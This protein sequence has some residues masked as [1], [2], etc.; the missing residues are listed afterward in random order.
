MSPSSSRGRSA[1]SLASRALEE[2]AEMRRNRPV[3]S[4]A[5]WVTRIPVLAGKG[6]VQPLHL[7]PLLDELEKI[8]RGEQ[9]R[10]VCHTPPRGGKT[11]TL[12]AAIS[13]WLKAHPT[14]QI[15]YTSYNATQARSKAENARDWAKAMG[16]EVT[17][18]TVVEWRTP[19]G[20]GCIAR[21]ISEGIT[22]QGVDVAIVDDPVKD[23]VEAESSLKRQRALDWFNEALFTRGN[24]NLIG[25]A[26]K[27]PRSII[28]NMARWHP[29]D[30]AGSLVAQG[31]KYIKLKAIDEVEINGALVKRSFWP[32]AWPVEQLEETREQIGD[33]SFESLYQGQPR[34]RGD[35]VFNDVVTHT[36][37][38]GRYRTAGGTDSAYSSK[39]TADRSAVVVMHAH[40]GKFYISKAKAMRV[41]A[42][43]FKAYCHA[44][45][46]PAMTWRWY[47]AGVELGAGQ[48]MAEGE[49]GIPLDC[50]IAT[51]DKFVRAIPFAAAWNAGKVSVDANMEG[52]DEFL[53]EM[54]SFTGVNDKRDDLVDAAVA[55]Y[56]ELVSGG[57]GA[58]PI[59][60]P[61]R[62][63]SNPMEGM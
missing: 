56:D 58:G 52:L 11:E 7:K 55:A 53:A 43:A 30:L 50:R 34:A 20:G 27:K 44:L 21:G 18:D 25:A 15:A 54:A 24:P 22:G 62:V 60:A 19:Q 59:T 4:I 31:W 10:V 33:F 35:Q 48:F 37:L 17:R 14:W 63:Q 16:V 2:L 5:E 28:V 26:E 57:S 23:R 12:L 36:E 8:Q 32:Q 1:P 6:Y 42:P 47:A 38:P 49:D 41:P 9:V 46:H 51:A 13:W 39:K 40:D 29:D 61:P 3:P 45:H